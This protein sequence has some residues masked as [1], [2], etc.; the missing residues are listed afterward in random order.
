MPILSLLASFVFSNW[1]Y[2]LGGL[3]VLSAATFSIHVANSWCNKACSAEK[4]KNESLEK[5]ILSLREQIETTNRRATH[6]ALL[7]SEEVLKVQKTYEYEYKQSQE[8]LDALQKRVRRLADDN[9]TLR[10]TNDVL[11]MLNDATD[12]ANRSNSS[13]ARDSSQGTSTVSPTP[14]RN[15]AP[16]GVMISESDFA[17]SWIDA[18]KSYSSCKT[19][20]M[21]CVDSYNALR[22]Q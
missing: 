19:A 4:R 8:N 22:K 16:E 3:L 12:E 15:E 10:V 9:A 2:I 7:W 17:N 5:A 13:V 14:E 20:W 21:A 6:L 18:A 11:R 1:K